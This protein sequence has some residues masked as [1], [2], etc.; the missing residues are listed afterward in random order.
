MAW[1]LTIPACMAFGGLAYFILSKASPL[2]LFITGIIV[3][4]L[5]F[6]GF[7]LKLTKNYD[8]QDKQ[9]SLKN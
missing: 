5:V 6:I 1:V 2:S 8:L 4:A 7:I 9:E 3:V